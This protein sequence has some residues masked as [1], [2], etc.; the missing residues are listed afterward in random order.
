MPLSIRAQR[1]RARSALFCRV[2]TWL[3]A[4]KTYLRYQF[5]GCAWVCDFLSSWE[6]WR[7]TLR[8][9]WGGRGIPLLEIGS[10]MKGHVSRN[11]WLG[12][13]S[14]LCKPESPSNRHMWDWGRFC[15]AASFWPCRKW[16]ALQ[17]TGRVARKIFFRVFFQNWSCLHL[18]CVISK[19]GLDSGLVHP[20]V[21]WP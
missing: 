4:Y 20:G 2:H 14:D 8:R 11:G 17:S 7:M 12:T 15:L 1:G 3:S 18:V 13:R 9:A 16:P 5:A 19:N 6:T 21:I 10:P